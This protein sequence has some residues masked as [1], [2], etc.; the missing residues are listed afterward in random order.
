MYS[1]IYFLLLARSLA[2]SWVEQISVIENGEFTGG[3]GYPRGYIARSQPGFG[4]SI[5][6]NLLPRNG[7]IS[8]DAS[9]AVCSPRQSF[10]VQTPGYDRLKAAAGAFVALKYLE[11]GH[12]SLPQN[13][14]GKPAGGGVIYIYGT[15]SPR[16]NDSLTEI[17]TW[18]SNRLSQ[19]GFLLTSQT[20][21]DGRCYQLNQGEIALE[22]RKKFPN[23]VPGQGGAISEQWCETDVR[24]PDNL[25]PGTILT[26]YW[27]WAWPTVLSSGR[28]EEY[29]TTCS[30]VDIVAPN[31]GYQVAI[32]LAQ[33][34]PQ[35]AAVSN[36]AARAS[37]AQALQSS[38]AIL[39]DIVM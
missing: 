16:S 4:D 34:D 24:L 29:Y 38:A 30:D 20:F 28:K 9:D 25:L 13:S 37:I 15:S 11:N 19:R 7:R 5:M 33:Q 35:T 22:R 1:Y 36:F 21:N 27:V 12:V 10:P 8:L 6:T 23:F 18:D 3:Y 31:S 32:P 39:A 26:L 14:P 2:H 17:I